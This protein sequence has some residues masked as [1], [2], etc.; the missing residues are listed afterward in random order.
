M[1]GIGENRALRGM[2]GVGDA[3]VFCSLSFSFAVNRFL[4]RNSGDA[5]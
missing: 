1:Q 2:F 4:V 5:N 3:E